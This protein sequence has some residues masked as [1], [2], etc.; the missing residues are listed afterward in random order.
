MFC[1]GCKHVFLLFIHIPNKTEKYAILIDFP[2][3]KNTY[4]LSSTMYYNSF[5]SNFTKDS[6]MRQTYINNIL[7]TASGSR[8]R[9]VWETNGTF[10]HRGMEPDF[11]A[12]AMAFSFAKI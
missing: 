10:Y 5:K 2:Y 6:R 4:V 7:T 11:W 1:Y 3:N 8:C 9:T 12:N